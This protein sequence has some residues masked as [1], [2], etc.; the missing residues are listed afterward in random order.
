MAKAA[1][2]HAMRNRQVGG[3]REGSSGPERRVGFYACSLLTGKNG[4]QGRTVRVALK[5]DTGGRM[6][7]SYPKVRRLD[8]PCGNEHKAG[9]MWRAL[10]EG[11]PVDAEILLEQPTP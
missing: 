9:L 10:K 3:F 7:G 4:L 1:H 2:D 5:G 8:C 6:P 11:E